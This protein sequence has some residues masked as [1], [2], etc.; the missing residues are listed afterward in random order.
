MSDSYLF[1]MT[2]ATAAVWKLHGLPGLIDV[3]RRKVYWRHQYVRFR[4]NLA[5]WRITEPSTRPGVEAREGTFE[6]LKRFRDYRAGLPIQFYSDM[7]HGARRFYLGLVDG[8]IGHIS[9][10]YTHEDHVHHMRLAPGEIMLEGAYTF[11]DFR[12]R[13]LLSAVERAALNDAQR[14]GKRLAFTHVAVDN[15]ASLRGV[16]KTGFRPVGILTWSWILGVSATEYV[17][18]EETA[19]HAAGLADGPTMSPAEA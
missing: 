18:S 10:V 5:E 15:R 2:R 13:G 1:R 4:V 16:W 8:E 19:V 12:G 17:D 14:E 9:W 3:A 7:L 11:A 6:E